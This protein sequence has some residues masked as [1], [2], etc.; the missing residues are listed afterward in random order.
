[1]KRLSPKDKKAV[2]DYAGENGCRAFEV[3]LTVRFVSEDSFAD[4]EEVC[5]RVSN[6]FNPGGRAEMG[7]PIKTKRVR[8][9]DKGKFVRLPGYLTITDLTALPMKKGRK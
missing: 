6:R 2:Q 8:G 9:V 1:M 5:R 4:V 3:T 7:M